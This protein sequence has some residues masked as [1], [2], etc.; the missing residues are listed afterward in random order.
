MPFSSLFTGFLTSAGLIV[1]IGAQNAFVL[2]QGLR[3]EHVFWVCL[4]CACSD[5]LLIAAGVFGMGLFVDA[6]PSFEMVMRAGGVA[7][8]AAYGA[9]S[10][11][12]AWRGGASV[13]QDRAE[14]SGNFF[15]IILQCLLLT[16]LNPHAYLDTVVLIGSIAARDPS[17]TVFGLGAITASFAFFFTLGFG[18]RLVAPWFAKPAT[19]RALD[20]LVGVTM[21]VIALGLAWELAA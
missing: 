8:L 20:G 19:W 10:F 3:Q 2:R 13:T 17:P 11:W 4:T 16:W 9:R 5:A 7:F 6:V 12:S 18:A 14:S 21:W 15:H 1:A